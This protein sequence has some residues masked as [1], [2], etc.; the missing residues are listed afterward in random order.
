[1]SLEN[2][3]D[4]EMMKTIME[5]F[6]KIKEQAGIE[7]DDESKKEI[8]ELYV[9][10]VIQDGEIA[11]VINLANQNNLDNLNDIILSSKEIKEKKRNKA[12]FE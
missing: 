7:P 6:E 10:T 8:E 3:I 9:K 1:M 2:Q 4:P 11:E 12:Q 5:Q